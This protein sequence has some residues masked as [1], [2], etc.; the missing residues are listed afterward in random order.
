MWLLSPPCQPHTRQ[1]MKKDCDDARS[2]GLLHIVSLLQKVKTIPDYLLL[3]NVEGFEVSQSREMLINVL[4]ERSYFYQEFILSPNQFQIPNQRDRY[5][6]IA[7]RT[8]FP[9][10][11]ASIPRLGHCFRVIPFHPTCVEIT[12][13]N[14]TAEMGTKES[15]DLWNTLNEKCRP[16]SD[17]LDPTIVIGTDLTPH[18]VRHLHLQKSGAHMDIVTPEDK[19]S[20]CF[21]KAYRKYHT[22]TGSLLQTATPYQEPPVAR[23]IDNLLSLK[24]R[25]FTGTEMKRLHGFPETFDFPDDMPENQRAKLVGNISFEMIALYCLVL[26]CSSFMNRV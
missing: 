24:L 13:K 23:D 17:F 12:Y 15:H 7:R 25:Y 22:G 1:G 19:Y 21:T 9:E 3:E 5:F 26:H 20:C 10:P 4:K 18:Y 16:L 2:D 11:P 8:A 14:G 6:L